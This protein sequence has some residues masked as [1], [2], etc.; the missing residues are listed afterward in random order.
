ML[1]QFLYFFFRVLPFGAS[2]LGILMLTWAVASIDDKS[3]PWAEFRRIDL[4][5]ALSTSLADPVNQLEADIS[6][7]AFDLLATDPD[8]KIRKE[9]QVPDELRPN[10]NFWL[11]IYTQYTSQH[12]VLLDEKHPEVIYEVLDFRDLAKHSRNAAAFEIVSERRIKSTIK[13]YREAFHR[14]GLKN[15]PRV[16]TAVELKVLSAIKKIRHKHTFKELAKNLR[17]QTGQRDNIIHGMLAAE[18]Y[19]PKME[20][21][22]I[23]QGLPPE[24]TRLSL[25]ESSFNLKAVSRVG[26]TGVWQF[27]PLSAKEYMKLD[28]HHE[29][30]E[31][32]S[33]LKA[34]LGAAKMLKRN[35]HVLKSWPLAI[36]SYNHG[37]G[38]LFKIP[39]VDRQTREVFHYFD[40]CHK[41]KRLGWASR[42]YYPGFL[43]VIYANAYKNFF[44]GEAP[45]LP[46]TGVQFVRL[47]KPTTALHI[48]LEKNIPISEFRT[49]NPDVRNLNSVLPTGFHYI[50]PSTKD[51]LVA[52]L[53]P[54]RPIQTSAQPKS[55][56]KHKDN[57]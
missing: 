43:A 46:H 1:N 13:A 8:H 28:P 41:K 14:L 56:R 12:V 35:M 53:D 20:K 5:A 31:R 33:P 19:L 55:K 15:P 6:D 37:I 2:L 57:G 40:P 52:L 10:F 17:T 9:F 26:A 27:M 44:Y 21:I 22:F 42:N 38:G 48:A 11:R 3:Y 7:R 16:Y 49:L 36:T 23:D 45:R 4:N 24:I 51:D 30:D 54:Q 50:L 29:I 32:L 47:N 34:T 25:L 39:V 18:M